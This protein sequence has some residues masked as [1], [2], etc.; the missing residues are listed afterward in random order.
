MSFTD[1]LSSTKCL[2]SRDLRA[3][4]HL[5]EEKQ[6][7]LRMRPHFAVN[8]LSAYF[9]LPQPPILDQEQ[10]EPQRNRIE[11]IDGVHSLLTTR[12]IAGLCKSWQV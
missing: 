7:L 9:G 4:K 12:N 3:V 2:P 1:I 6:H 10:C 5:S 11:L 8:L